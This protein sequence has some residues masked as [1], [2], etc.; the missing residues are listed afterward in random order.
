MRRPSQTVSFVCPHCQKPVDP[1]ALNAMLSAASTQWQH[2]DC[3]TPPR[4]PQE[5]NPESTGDLRTG[6]RT[7][8]P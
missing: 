5:R 3:W 1:T 7:E 2:T 8:L 4:T 6:E